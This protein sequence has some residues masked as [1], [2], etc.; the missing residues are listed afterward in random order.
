[1]SLFR[2]CY[3]SP[4]GAG[5]IMNYGY[6]PGQACFNDNGRVVCCFR[7][8]PH[9]FSGRGSDSGDAYTP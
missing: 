9:R 8:T 2:M 5:L 1:M 3:L 6:V 7:V 4:F